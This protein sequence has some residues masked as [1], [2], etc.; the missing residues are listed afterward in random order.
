MKKS[1]LL[2]DGHALAYRY[3]FALERSGMKTADGRPIWA[4]FGFFKCMFD[5][6]QESKV[7][8]DLIA[9]TF[10]VARVTFRCELYPEYKANR[11]SMPADM[12]DQ[13]DD[14]IEGLHAFNIP[15]YTKAGFEADDVIGTIAER[16]KSQNIKVMILTGDRDSFQLV[17]D[18]NDVTVIMPS[19]GEIV[20]Y[21]REK[22]FERM[23]VYPEQVVDLKG[24]AG[25]TSDNIPGIRGIGDKTAAKLL[26]QYQTLEGIYEHVVE[27]SGKALKQKLI[28]GKSDALLSKELATI[29]R[30]VDVDF[31]FKETC[32]EIENKEAVMDFF[33]K[34]S[35]YNFMKNSDKIFS[36]F[37][38]CENEQF[39][40]NERYPMPDNVGEQQQLSL[41]SHE[42]VA[43]NGQLG[44]F[45][46]EVKKMRGSYN[47]ERNLVDTEEKLN[48]MIET[49]KS[50]NLISVDTETTGL[51]PLE[52]DIVGLSIAFND[53]IISKNGRVK[54][55][56]TKENVTVCYYVPLFH[57]YGEQVD[58][59][60]AVNSLA[61]IFADEKISKTMQNAKFDLHVLKHHN[62]PVSG[63]IF[64]TMLASYIYDSSRKHG[65]KTQ[66]AMYL[67][68]IM[69]EYEEVAGKDVSFDT[70]E[71]EKAKNYACDD[72]FATL[73]LTRHWQNTLEK[74]ELDLLYDVEVPTTIVLTDMEEVGVSID[75]DYLKNLSQETQTE[76]DNVEAKI[77]AESGESFNVNSPKQVKSILFDKM[78]LRVR[79]R[80]KA[81]QSTNA[82][83]LEELALDYPIAK[84]ILEQRHL[85]KLKS[86]YIDALPNLISCR[87]NRI[88]TSFNQTITTTGRLSS[89][90]PNLQNIPARSE[91]GEKIR[92]AFVPQNPEN[93]M[94][95]ADYSQIELRLLAHCSQDENLM[96]AFIDDVDVHTLTASKIFDV[97]EEAVTKDMRRKAKAVNFGIVYGQSKYGLA[98][99]LDISPAKADEFII[100]Y[101][102]TYPAIQ[103]YM[104]KT[105]DYAREYG[106]VK[107]IYGRKR[108]FD[109]IIY[110]TST[111]EREAGERAAINAPLQGSAADLIKK[112]M[113]DLYN[114]IKQ[115]NLKSKIVIQ[116]HDELVLE[117]VQS[118][119][120]LVSELVKKAM[121]QGQPLTVPLKVDM[122][123]GQNLMEM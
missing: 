91:L 48:K 34:N 9:V 52:D 20:T 50:K 118:E 106:Y 72:V 75:K 6:L 15:I 109:T 68:Y 65:L 33:K 39:D 28:D 85:A 107:T 24:L 77:F 100:K 110:A 19:K 92:G 17:D 57:N 74:E 67:N 86:T 51:N 66:S 113:I 111:Q 42:T 2:I 93:L 94:L 41:T 45:A 13:F 14:I 88:H 22:V 119:R 58:F 90:N 40:P 23:G 7:N 3:Y 27:V 37:K 29:K 12:H 47:I 102:Q 4:V 44:L 103:K 123:F 120:D 60:Y 1:L 71:I 59:D 53:Q 18:E 8:P 49:L 95:S 105:I 97:P 56:E 55:D 38:L 35:F 87:D 62:M 43:E 101:F 32:L 10:D 78:G 80:K 5:L 73:E 99:Q 64:D 83:V 11:E 82:K 84:Y 98:S 63:L 76:I 16:A 31:D 108:W 69:T 114:Y 81:S 96:Q 112:A 70:V 26:S 104:L 116:V 122:A 36:H 117:V 25:D 61:P 54:F 30:D 79:G 46:T 21:N 121:E 115:M 89:S